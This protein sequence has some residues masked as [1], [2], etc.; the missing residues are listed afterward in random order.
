[1]KRY[2]YKLKD[3]LELAVLL[4]F[5]LISN[6]LNRK[7]SYLILVIVVMVFVFASCTKNERARSFGGTE[8]V[9]L[10]K[11]EKF[12]NITWKND[13]LWII[14]QDT[15]SGTIYAKEK[16]SYG[17]YEGRIIIKKSKESGGSKIFK[18]KAIIIEKGSNH[19]TYKSQEGNTFTIPDSKRFI[20]PGEIGDSII[21]SF[22]DE[23][24]PI[25]V[26][27]RPLK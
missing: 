15:I 25:F 21:V 4:L 2:L 24:N 16:S 22:K 17:I 6:L 5:G 23:Y 7:I 26:D 13:D 9:T 10:G 11:N 14:V 12:L 1:M 27:V 18:T 19:L 3:S 8:E 20:D